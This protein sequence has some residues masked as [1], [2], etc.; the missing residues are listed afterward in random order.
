MNVSSIHCRQHEHNVVLSVA[1]SCRNV[2]LSNTM[3]SAHFFIV[4]G[5]TIILSNYCRLVHE[6]EAMKE[7]VELKRQPE[8]ENHL[9]KSK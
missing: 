5:H 3:H 4:V 9:K 7:A 2:V 8:K 1:L 6:I